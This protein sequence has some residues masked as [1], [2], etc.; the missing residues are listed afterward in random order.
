MSGAG[1]QPSGADAIMAAIGQAQGAMAPVPT[2][3]PQMS[4]SDSI[5]AAINQA[6]AP[7]GGSAPP[8]PQ[9][10]MQPMPHEQP[11]WRQQLMGGPVGQF[12]AGAMQP[13]YGLDQ[14]AYKG[15]G[16]ATSLGG[17]F[18]NPVSNFL[19]QQA[20]SVGDQAQQS[21]QSNALART[22][23]GGNPKN[24]PEI[25]GQMA[26]PANFM[27][28]GVGGAAG[29][30][31]A[32]LQGVAMGI[33]APA[34]NGDDYWKQK[35]EQA[36][37]GAV[38]GGI[39]HGAGK[40][41]S[42]I[43]DPGSTYGKDVATLLK[44]NVPLTVGQILGGSAHRL[45]D[46]ATSIPFVGD[47]VK[48]RQRDAF[49]GLNTA[50]INRSLTPI[51]DKLPE[52]LTGHAAI[53]YAQ[54]SL[55]N[56][57]DELLPQLSATKDLQLTTDLDGIVNGAT[58]TYGLV[59]PAKDKLESIVKNQVINKSNQGVYDGATLKDIQ[60]NLSYQARTHSKSLNPDDKNLADALIDTK[61]AVNDLIARHNPNEAP[62]LAAINEGW[63]NFARPPS[64]QQRM[65]FLH[66]LNLAWPFD[67]VEP[68]HR[69]R[70]EMR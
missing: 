24:V 3:A 58:Q 53:D 19:D 13:I 47:M 30:G 54:S 16:S 38:T 51:G 43:A 22:L 57:Y 56:A 70:Q 28:G 48:A 29:M 37:I 35:A 66:P 59:G 52:G 6:Q 65:E 50:A 45:E 10:P 8:P 49:L 40:T 33:T 27:A 20:N 42:A 2:S 67:L 23:T 15:L 34:E 1:S 31:R 55:G 69:T 61:T 18:P 9:D 25:L 64:A 63:A 44:A 62:Q 39:M 21:K 60:S 12:M 4:G 17:N 5:M 36:G 14:L 46:A 7:V 11:N 26:S 32:L 41:L 68:D